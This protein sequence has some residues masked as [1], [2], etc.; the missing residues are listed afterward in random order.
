MGN[1]SLTNLLGQE[2]QRRVTPPC[3]HLDLGFQQAALPALVMLPLPAARQFLLL[4]RLLEA[5]SPDLGLLPRFELHR[6][7]PQ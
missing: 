7:F 1:G 2:F 3:Q 4:P 6:S 5:P